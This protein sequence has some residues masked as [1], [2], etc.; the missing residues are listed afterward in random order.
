MSDI[1]A[2]MKK[3]GYM[4]LLADTRGGIG[5][6]KSFNKK[7]G[8]L[9]AGVWFDTGKKMPDGVTP[10]TVCA[11]DEA[12]YEE[13]T[14]KGWKPVEVSPGGRSHEQGGGRKTHLEDVQASS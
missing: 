9:G 5:F 2:A 6:K 13:Y 4:P 7:A 11:A 8:A 12:A 14:G 3:K 1:A 10:R